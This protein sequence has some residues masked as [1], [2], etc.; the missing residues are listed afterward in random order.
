MVISLESQ[1]VKNKRVKSFDFS[2]PSFLKN[3]NISFDLINLPF[4]LGLFI[5]SVLFSNGFSLF[6]PKYSRSVEIQKVIL[7]LNGVE[8][9]NNKEIENFS[10]INNQ[11]YFEYRKI[12]KGDTL[13]SLSIKYNVSIQSILN[14]N[15]IQDITKIDDFT[16]L[17]I[18]YRD[19]YLHRLTAKDSLES[20][21]NKYGV[22]V[23]EIFTANGLKSE[24]IKGLLELYIPMVKPEDYGWKSNLDKFLIYPTK[25]SISKRYGLHT[26][27]ITGLTSFY[28][29]IDFTPGSDLKVFASKPGFISLI[30]YSP[31]YGNYVYIDH[32]GGLRTLYA[33]LENITVGLRDRV[34]QGDLIAEIG[35]SGFTSSKKLFFAVLRSDESV[36]PEKLLK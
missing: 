21:S 22:E 8:I 24:N 2:L 33:H 11:S 18:P 31:N 28:E 27:S 36:D 13:S 30:G 7:P 35:S 16:S 9:L 32:S 12:Y 14:V 26:N 1:N 3:I 15:K 23:K 29:G 34:D 10:G 25:G 4:I 20:L 17:K 19:G 5:Y 6:I